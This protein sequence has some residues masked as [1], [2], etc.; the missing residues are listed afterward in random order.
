MAH[1]ILVA[2]DFLDEDFVMYLGDNILREGIVE[3]AKNFKENNHDASIMLT[4]VTNPEHFGIAEII[5]INK[6]NQTY[7]VGIRS[8][9]QLRNLS[10]WSRCRR[11]LG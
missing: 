2:E 1:A 4:E 3:H 10:S 7:S 6:T 11:H 9:N 5:V 8:S